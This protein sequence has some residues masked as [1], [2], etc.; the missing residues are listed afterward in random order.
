MKNLNSLSKDQLLILHR[1]TEE[2]L[3]IEWHYG[4]KAKIRRELNAIK[5]AIINRFPEFR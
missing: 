2:M 5:T 4:R 3:H 1:I